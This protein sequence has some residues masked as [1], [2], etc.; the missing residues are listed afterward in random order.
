LIPVGGLL[1][2]LRKLRTFFGHRCGISKGAIKEFRGGVE[3][4]ADAQI[5]QNV[6]ACNAIC[7]VIGNVATLSVLRLLV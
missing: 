2:F 6:L 5:D 7:N 1:Q 4:L 3:Q